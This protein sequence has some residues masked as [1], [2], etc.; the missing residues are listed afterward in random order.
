MILDQD[1]GDGSDLVDLGNW[2]RSVQVWRNEKVMN[3][4][5]DVNLVS[6]I[7]PILFCLLLI[8]VF[9]PDCEA[10]VV[11]IVLGQLASRSGST[12]NLELGLPEIFDLLLAGLVR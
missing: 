9:G 1:P 3:L 6:I 2:D 10:A 4:G 5:D 11:R 12:P 7:D 8:F